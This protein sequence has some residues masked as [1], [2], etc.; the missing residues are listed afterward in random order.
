MGG[1]VKIA[2]SLVI[3]SICALCADPVLHR[4]EIWGGNATRATTNAEKLLLYVGWTNGFFMARDDRV[5]GLLACLQHVDYN[6]AIAMIDKHYK[7]H[8]ERWTRDFGREL[9][10]ALTVAGG[11]CEG[12]NPFQPE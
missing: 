7:D 4:F 8:P 12:K 1:Y 10:N 11:P 9:L 6:Q 5:A 2:V 3:F